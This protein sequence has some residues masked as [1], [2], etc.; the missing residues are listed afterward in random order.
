MDNLVDET[1]FD[2]VGS[3]GANEDVPKI[4]IGDEGNFKMPSLEEFMEM[5]ENMDSMSD[6]EKLQLKSEVLKNSMKGRRLETG[7]SDYLVFL[8]MII[9]I[10][11][12]FGKNF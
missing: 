10:A 6:E 4:P 12:V 3:V 1:A 9:I 5:L 11:S 7:F 8:T 2:K